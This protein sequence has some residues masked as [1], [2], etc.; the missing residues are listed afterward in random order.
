MLLGGFTGVFLNEELG[1]EKLLRRRWGGC[2]GRK[3]FRLVFG[4]HEPSNPIQS[5]AIWDLGPKFM[6]ISK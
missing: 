4:G 5:F 3:R 6:K 2:A 1:G